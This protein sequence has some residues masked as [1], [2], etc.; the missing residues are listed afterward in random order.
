MSPKLLPLTDPLLV[1]SHAKVVRVLRQIDR[2]DLLAN[3]REMQVVVA[4]ERK[5]LW[6]CFQWHDDANGLGRIVLCCPV[7]RRPATLLHEYAHAL[8]HWMGHNE[9]DD[10]GYRFQWMLKQLTEGTETP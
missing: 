2:V 1:E 5:T 10:H 6:G 3:V 8:V 4:R 7:W 9:A